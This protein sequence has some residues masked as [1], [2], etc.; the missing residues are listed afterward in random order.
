[1]RKSPCLSISY[2]VISFALV[3]ESV[4]FGATAREG[5]FRLVDVWPRGKLR[6]AEVKLPLRVLARF[7]QEVVGRRDVG[8]STPVAIVLEGSGAREGRWRDE[9]TYELTLSE[10]ESVPGR[11]I[12]WS[13]P[14]GLRDAKGRS[15]TGER[16]FSFVLPSLDLLAVRQ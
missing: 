9:R 5:A 3:L 10:E 12:R 16:S 8:S 7:S 6:P 14:A 4:A 13:V 15:L 1:M 11:E 2:F